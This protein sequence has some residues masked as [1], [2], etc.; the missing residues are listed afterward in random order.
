MTTMIPLKPFFWI[1]DIGFILY[2]LLTALQLIPLEYAFNDYKNP[3]LV[4]WNWSFFPLDMAIS[5]TGL[6]ALWLSGR[7]QSWQGWAL[8]SLTL[9]FVAGLNA[10]A[11]WA[12]RGEFEAQWWIPN[13]YLMLYPLWFIPRLLNSGKLMA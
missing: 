8:V 12:V 10:L 9:T 2:W 13:L 5:F 1:T 3:I 11:F 6:Y 4:A 7:G